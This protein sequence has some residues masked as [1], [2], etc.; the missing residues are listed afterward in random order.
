MSHEHTN[1]IL[2]GLS[3]AQKMIP[4]KYLYDKKGSEIFEE[5]CELPEYY[6]TRSEL[7]I[8]TTNAREMAAL[9]GKDALIIEPGC[10]NGKKVRSLLKQLKSPRG[11][12]PLE[13]SSEMLEKVSEE[14][15][16]EFPELEVTPVC[17]DFTRDDLE[18]EV[19]K[20]FSSNRRVIFFP[21]STIGNLLPKDAIKLLKKFSSWIGDNGGILIG[22]DLKKDHRTLELAY[23]DPKGVTANFNLNLLDR[24]NEEFGASFETQNFAHEAFYN[25]A[26]GRVEMHL[27]SKVP[28]QVSMGDTVINFKSGETIHTEN[29]YKY[30]VDEF[31]DLATRAQL[32]LKSYWKD[33]RNLFCVYYFEKD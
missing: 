6:P 4:P 22:V 26:L 12:I 30:T 31:C 17:D 9:I 16:D 2:E 33:C 32:F 20:E 7:E 21:G 19:L 28:Q 25:E 23:D 13:I 5:I 18:L 29:S 15:Q 1:E 8:L 24:L 10:G 11:Y 27:K 14:I 3:Q